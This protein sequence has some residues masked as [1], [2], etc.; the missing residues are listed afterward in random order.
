MVRNQ[1]VYDYLWI[2]DCSAVVNEKWLA[3]PELLE[4]FE[5]HQISVD[6]TKRGKM[7]YEEYKAIT[8]KDVL[9]RCT[10]KQIVIKSTN[11]IRSFF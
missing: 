8:M 6:W 9:K 10:F 2:R 5:Q 4:F 3:E 11:R 1:P 7:T